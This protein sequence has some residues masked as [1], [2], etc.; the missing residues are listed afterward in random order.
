MEATISQFNR[1]GYYVIEE[2]LDEAH[3][4]RL[5]TLLR[6][7]RPVLERSPSRKR[8]EVLDAGRVLP[9]GGLDVRNIVTTQRCAADSGPDDS[10]A[11]YPFLH[12]LE[13]EAT[14]PVALRALGSPHIGL[15]TSH[16][17]IA[18]PAESSDERNIGWHTDGGMPRFAGADGVRPFQQLKIGY[19]L[20]D[21]PRDNMGGLC[22]VP[23]SHKLAAIGHQSVEAPD[24]DGAVQL[25][26]RAGDAVIF[27]QG[28]WHAAAPNTDAAARERVA[29]YFGYGAR[30][31]RPMDFVPSRLDARFLAA[32]SPTQSQLMGIL[33]TSGPNPLGYWV[34]QPGD[35]PL[36]E[37]YERR[38][39]C[40]FHRA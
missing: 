23:G 1:D 25:K 38:F 37:V 19:F 40:P 5:H 24:M 9:S 35:V 34:P 6:E 30:T 32:L 7:L 29:I 10:G 26:L 3:V 14:F 31:L 12:L 8:V 18:P 33:L 16:L 2:A 22:V 4:A 15:L 39:G 17:I 11:T 21:L 20:T 36:A 27:Q 13:H 28:L